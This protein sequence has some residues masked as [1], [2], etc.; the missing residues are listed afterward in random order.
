[1]PHHFSLTIVLLL[2]LQMVVCRR[3]HIALDTV[4]V[5]IVALLLDR[6]AKAVLKA[7]HGGRI[8][9]TLPRMRAGKPSLVASYPG[10]QTTAASSS[11]QRTV[12]L[13]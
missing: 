3:C 13:R 6:I 4:L 10:S 8:T 9:V 5:S 2:S 7:S 11:A 1:M 12:R